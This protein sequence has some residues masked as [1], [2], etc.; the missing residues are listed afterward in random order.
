MKYGSSPQRKLKIVYFKRWPSFFDTM[1]YMS[2]EVIK[3]TEINDQ[4]CISNESFPPT[5]G[6]Q[7][8]SYYRDDSLSPKNKVS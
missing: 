8:R 2:W 6:V 4:D 3:V 5:M 1:Y 7:S